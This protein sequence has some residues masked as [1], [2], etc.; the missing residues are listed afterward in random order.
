MNSADGLRR[1]L[2]E[3]LDGQAETAREALAPLLDY[4]IRHGGDLVRTLSVYLEHGCNATRCAESLYLHRSGLLY[5]L[6]RIE[7]LLGVRL[8]SYDIR[9][10][11]E[12]ATM[13]L[14]RE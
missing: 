2:R 4:D 12:I 3:A 8:D 11:L 14:E 13:A 7:D 5:R 6:G 9:V 1:L 10:A